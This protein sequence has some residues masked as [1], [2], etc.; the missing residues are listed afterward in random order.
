MTCERGRQHSA[1][2]H[3]YFA[4]A[5]GSAPPCAPPRP[6]SPWKKEAAARGACGSGCR[7]G[8]V[9]G[10]AG[11]VSVATAVA[12]AATASGGATIERGAEGGRG[13]P[14]TTPPED[15]DIESRAPTCGGAATRSR[16][17]TLTRRRGA[18]DAG[19]A[20]T[21][22]PDGVAFSCWSAVPGLSALYVR[23]L[24][25]VEGV[26]GT[27]L[28]AGEGIIR[29]LPLSRLAV[30]EER[31]RSV[32]A[33]AAAAEDCCASIARKNVPS[34]RGCCVAAT[35]TCATASPR[36]WSSDASAVLLNN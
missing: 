12:E 14:A 36:R 10:S 9:G 11:A 30:R 6:L 16:G 21:D 13:R 23:A 20:A 22:L 32:A 26:D 7:A 8:T 27:P 17:P 25:G 5:V 35:R 34:C 24:E 15:D 2:G 18:T 33:A 19:D 31:P 3:R 28:S 4:P 1:S 29:T